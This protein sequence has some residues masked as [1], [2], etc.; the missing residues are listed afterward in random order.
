MVEDS[1]QKLVL[2]DAQLK[3]IMTAMEKS[4]EEGLARETAHKATV[5]MLPTYVCSVPNGSEKGNF[6]ALDLGGTNFRV[7]LIRL[8]DNEAE[9]LSK[10]FRVP[11][12]IM[13]GTGEALF[14]H[15]AECMAKFMDENGMDKSK[16]LP[17]GFTF[18]FP[19][20]QEGLTKGKLVS[21]TKGFNASGV[22][23][24]DVVE[25]LRDACHRRKDID[26]D[27]VALLNDT[28]GTLM[29]C[30]YQEN[31]CQIGIIVGTGT[32]ACYMEDMTKIGKLDDYLDE[33]GEK[34]KEMCIN[35]EWGAF[36]DDGTMS[37]A[38]TA[39]DDIVDAESINP[40]KQLFEKMISGMYM[41]EL[42][43]VVLEDLTRQKLLFG[44]SVDAIKQ[45]NCFPTKF[46]SEIDRDLLEDEDKTFQ[47]TFQ[48]LEDIGIENVS[49]N[50]CANVAYVCS[51]VS[52]RAAHLTAAGIAML[53]NRMHKKFITV[54]VD[55]SVYRFHPTYPRLL[56][57]KIDDLLSRDVEFQLMLSEDGS[58]RGAA[59]V[60]AVATRIKQ[61][62][63]DGQLSK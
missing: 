22:E 36:G 24:A 50:D 19:C 62:K 39:W 57:A 33:H 56:D 2:T 46:V 61:E 4:M 3:K 5:K 30:A 43:R 40:G 32:N 38:R 10:I 28:V 8:K 60:A 54:G 55:G 51:L 7:L 23:G 20:E 17:L 11:E 53:L 44:G 63:L 1:C 35:T 37:W 45:K 42:V 25:L 6:L 47:K 13:K 16:R 21:W 48:I 41:G 15:I 49:N 58:G 18:S 59:L 52:T 14:D 31:S 34:P 26:I 9:M 27:V 12:A 29:A